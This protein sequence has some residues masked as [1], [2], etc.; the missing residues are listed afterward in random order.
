MAWW[1]NSGIMKVIGL[2]S[3]P[4]AHGASETD[5]F[6]LVIPSIPGYGYSPEPTTLGWD[7]IRVAK[8]WVVLMQRLG[9]PKFVDLL[10]V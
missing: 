2:L 1:R 8:A 3:D 7:P 9:Y 6:H 10:Q 5:A 4:T